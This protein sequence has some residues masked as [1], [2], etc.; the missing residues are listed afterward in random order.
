M[1]L[2]LNLLSDYPTHMTI[3]DPFTISQHTWDE[4]TIT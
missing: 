1:H 3:A 2:L 4:T